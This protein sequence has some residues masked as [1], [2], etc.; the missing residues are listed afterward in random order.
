MMRYVDSPARSK[1]ARAFRKFMPAFATSSMGGPTLPPPPPMFADENI[2]DNGERVVPE[3]NNFCF[4]AHL[5]IYNFAKP[6]A[7]GKRVLDAGCGTGYGSFHLL[8]Q[9]KAK[10]VHGIDLSEKAIGFCRS[11]ARTQRT[12]RAARFPKMFAANAERL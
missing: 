10:S 3:D 1:L 4:H 7:H 9:G 2:T 6:Y 8:S 12:G 11:R 5:S